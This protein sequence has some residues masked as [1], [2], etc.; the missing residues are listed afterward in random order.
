M[1]EVFWGAVLLFGIGC[2]LGAEL[3]RRKRS[4]QECEF[5]MRTGKWPT[6]EE[7]SWY[8]LK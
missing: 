7:L 6:T 2:W 8:N 3:A 4:K 1:G 5:F